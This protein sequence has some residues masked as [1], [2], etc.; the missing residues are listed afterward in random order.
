M[1]YGAS[2]HLQLGVDGGEHALL[3]ARGGGDVVRAVDEDLGLDDRHEAELLA[4]ARVAGEVLRRDLDGE[5]GGAAVLDVDLER[6]P[7]LGETCAL[8]VVLLAALRQAVEATA[9][10][11]AGT[12]VVQRDQAGVDLDARNDVEALPSL[13]VGVRGATPA[14]VICEEAVR[15]D[16]REVCGRWWAG[17]D[18]HDVDERLAV[19]V[20]LEEGLLEEDGA[21]DV[22]VDARRGE[23]QVAPLL[24]VGLRVLHAVGLPHRATLG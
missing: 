22:L 1:G 23:E 8:L 16:A 10:L 24:A 9:P 5:V 4:D 7:P 2:A 13:G 14:G 20:V 17:G 11:L 3:D 15:A 6:R 21:R 18:L 19:G 12:A